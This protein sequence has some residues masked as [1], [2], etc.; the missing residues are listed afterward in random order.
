MFLE[1]HTKVNI[2]CTI[3]LYVIYQ[4]MCIYCLITNVVVNIFLFSN[5]FSVFSIYNCIYC[6]KQLVF[7]SSGYFSQFNLLHKGC[8]E[9][10]FAG[11]V[12][13]SVL[14]D[15]YSLKQS[16]YFL[17]RYQ[18]NRDFVCLDISTCILPLFC[19][20]FKLFFFISFLLFTVS[21]LLFVNVFTGVF[22]KPFIVQGL[23]FV[24]SEQKRS[25]CSIIILLA[26]SAFLYSKYIFTCFQESCFVL[27]FT[28]FLSLV[29]V[30]FLRINY[31]NEGIIHV[32]YINTVCACSE[33]QILHEYIL[34]NT[35]YYGYNSYCVLIKC[36]SFII[37][38]YLFHKHYGS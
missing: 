4:K 33:R 16:R 30:E 8:F 25:P 27:L 22:T 10:E 15:I 35:V 36:I 5:L 28:R 24:S 29:C 17:L 1:K 7:H 19:Y 2:L 13:L 18:I 21:N 3:I 11:V 9:A 38:V 31:A 20:Y 37:K 34:S 26:C 12:V 6:S 32:T 23:L 14:V